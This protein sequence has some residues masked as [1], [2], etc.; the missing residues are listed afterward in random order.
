MAY[1]FIPVIAK[2][3][4]D[5]RVTVWN[6]SRG[7]KQ[8]DKVLPQGIPEHIYKFPKKRGGRQCGLQITDEDLDEAAELAN[9]QEIDYVS[10]E[11]RTMCESIIAEPAEV[12]PSEL[13]DCFSYLRDQVELAKQSEEE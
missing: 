3:M 11:F 4:E 12:P 8:K 10:P 2:H 6:F 9:I 1:L 5:F 13:A 7:R